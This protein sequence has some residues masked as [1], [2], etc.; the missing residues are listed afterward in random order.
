MASVREELLCP[1]CLEIFTS[2]VT[3]LCGHNFCWNCISHALDRRASSLYTCPQCR[4]TFRSRPVLTK[5]TTL[6]NIARLFASPKVASVYCTY[7]EPLIPAIKTC[8]QCETSMCSRHLQHHNRSVEHDLMDCNVSLHDKKCPIHN[9]ILGYYCPMNATCICVSC[10]LSGEYRGLP[11]EPLN[12]AHDK[13]KEM[14]QK[15]LSILSTKTEDTKRRVMN[16]QNIQR[17]LR[18]V[19]NQGETLPGGTLMTEKKMSHV[20]NQIMEL[21]REKQQLEIK[22]FWVVELSRQMDPIYFL[23]DVAIDSEDCTET[24]HLD[25]AL[26]TGTAPKYLLDI[27]SKAKKWWFPNQRP[28]Y[29]IL[30]VNTAASNL[31]VSDHQK[32][33]TYMD[34]HQPRPE[35]PERFEQNQILS[36]NMFSSGRHYWDVECSQVGDWMIGVCYA[37]MDRKGKKSFL[38]CNSRSWCLRRRDNEFWVQHDTRCVHLPH[39]TSCNYVRVSLNCKVGQLTFH[40]VGCSIR[41]LYTYNIVFTEPLHAAFTLFSGGLAIRD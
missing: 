23:E 39:V 22:T 31:L 12:V 7:C 6:D 34:M 14:L 5:N 18:K 3:L 21:E 20:T 27:A 24:L 2:P 28:A 35:T 17:V 16:L 8:L 32:A 25:T 9:K 41:H 15:L 40:S 4:K 38:G 30:N 19:D 11:V 36:V 33:I 26:I 13:K 1:I 37:T 10:C 29:V